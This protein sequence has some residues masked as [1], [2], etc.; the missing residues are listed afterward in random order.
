MNAKKLLAALLASATAVC[1]IPFTASAADPTVMEIDGIRTAFVSSFGRISYNGKTYTSYKTFEEALA[2]LGSEGGDLVFN[3]TLKIGELK[4]PGNRGVITLKGMG[5]KSQGNLLDF[6]GTE[7]APVKEVN[8]KGDL[9][10]DFVNIRLDE[11]AYF[12]TNGHEI[13]TY[14]EFDTYHTETYVADGANIIKYPAPP[15]VAVGSADN[16]SNIV[17]L[18]SGVYATVAAGTIDGHTS[19]GD[20]FT[21]MNGDKAETLVAGSVGGTL[22]GDTKLT[23]NYGEYDT[24]VAGSKGGTVNGNVY[25]SVNGGNFGSAT[26]GAEE[27]ATINGSVIMALNGGTFSGNI[28]LGKGTVTGK[29]IVI[30]NAYMPIS[31][32][33]GAADYVIRTTDALCEPQFDESNN[34]TGFVISDTYGIPS[35]SV[36]INGETVTSE[37][38]VYQLPAGE[39]SI[40]VTNGVKMEIKKNAH[41]VAGYE[42]GT[43]APQNNMT[44][45]EAVTLLTRVLLDENLIKG[46]ITSTFKDVAADAWYSPYIGVFQRMGLLE[47]VSDN[48][49]T[50]FR[51]NDNI[52]RGEFT[53]LIY[54]VASVGGAS[55]S[56]KLRAFSDVKNTNKYRTAIF[57]AVSN[58]IV[59]GYDDG[60]F[61]PDKNIT[62]AEVVTMVNRFLGRT[63]SETDAAA[64]FSDI[65]GHWAK[66]QILAACG[67]ENVA[68]TATDL[69]A[70]DYTI[71]GTNYKDY[72][73]GLYNQSASL[74]A[75]AIRRGVDTISE[76]MKKD[77]L[78]TPN[79]ADIYG[80]RMT[81]TTYYISEKNGNDDNDGLSPEKALKTYAGLTK[82]MRFPKKGTSI[83]FERGGIY[84][85]QIAIPGNGITLGSYGEGP[86]PLLMQSRRDYADP[87]LW[88]ETEWENVWKCTELLN[89]VGVI[90]FDHD[91]FD[92]SD[93]SYDELYGEIMNYNLFGF[94]GVSQLS[95]D[96]QFYSVTAND[97]STVTKTNEL[98]LYSDKGNPG[99]R[100]KSIEIGENVAI[101]TGAANDVVID[102]LAFKFTGGHGMGG[103]GGCSDRVVTN[104]VF[105]W[106][107]GSVLSFNFGSSGRPVN[108]GNAVEIYGSCNGYRVEN[109]WMYQIYDTAVTHQYSDGTSCTQEGV[110]YYGL[111]MELCHWGIEFY[112][113]PGDGKTRPKS[114][115][116]KDVHIAYNVCRT[117]GMGWG[118]KVRYRTGLLYCGSSLS[119]NEDELTEYN[120]FDRCHGNLLTLPANSNEVDD[121]NIYIQTIG[122]RLGN[123]KGQTVECDY[124]AAEYI[125]KYWGDKNAVVIVIDPKIS[126]A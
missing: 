98:Y 77:I 40:S 21:V 35:E 25:V 95:K 17:T 87:S 16:I 64:N 41:Y 26:L 90:G 112:N 115:Y 1:A 82:K 91:L 45:A 97:P 63:P 104:C 74:S 109:C 119:T 2:A 58:N 92:Y 50:I 61:R 72:V 32:A 27:G 100:F 124:N 66:S 111:L 33:D 122:E 4:D 3:G 114:K 15:S 7:E 36:V 5:T 31:L 9:Y 79:T 39:S 38:C 34:V 67:D 10:M 80:D 22:N 110:R 55:D 51:P 120:I 108:Y 46:K 106:L 70:S 101:I 125:A 52:T 73:T 99:E 76:Q 6:T 69:T 117:G 28:A 59:M 43:F 68:W 18:D 81:G 60:T 96:L 83:L 71:T 24:L 105:S 121:K 13:N 113:A 48:G 93:D 75:D 116:T 84:R 29:K 42:N 37:N 14:N 56:V 12:L 88:V 62:R 44:K 126:A 118:T 8:L 85:G 53:Q 54:E 103:A 47:K 49:G 20:A 30:T 86:K 89:N 107:G 102:N 94:M 123:L 78:N 19:N 11:G 65:D 57:F 23:V